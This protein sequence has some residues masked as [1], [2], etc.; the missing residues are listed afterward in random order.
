VRITAL[1]H[2]TFLRVSFDSHLL[3]DINLLTCEF[4]LALSSALL[5]AMHGNPLSVPRLSLETVKEAKAASASFS[6]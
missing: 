2:F 5:R 4:R 3:V 1:G 6:D